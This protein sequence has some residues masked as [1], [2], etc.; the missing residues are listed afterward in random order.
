MFLAESTSGLTSGLNRS[1]IILMD[2]EFVHNLS[3]M[4]MAP[5]YLVSNVLADIPAKDSGQAALSN[6]LYT[7]FDTDSLE[8]GISHP[9]E[10]IIERVLRSSK[11]QHALEWL[12]SFSLDVSRPSFAS[13][14]LRCL[15]RQDRPGTVEWRTG[16]MQ[17]ALAVD[18][19]EMRDAAVQV[20]ELWGDPG[21]RAILKSHSES[22]PWLQ[23]Y[24]RDVIQDLG[25]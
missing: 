3:S 5:D 21:M 6:K 14:V 17:A 20:A 25:E 13:S 4:L 9:A 15:G 23:D 19:V 8:D 24:I 2:K 11:D 7:A 16:L 18:D 12:R 1:A 22:E 10:E